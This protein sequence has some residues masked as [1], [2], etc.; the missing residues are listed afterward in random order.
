MLFNSYLYLILFLP[1]TYAVYF[2]LNAK[3]WHRLALG[4]LTLAS[5][6]FY[7]FWNINHLPI[8]L[9]SI[10]GN[11]LL[12]SYLAKGTTTPRKRKISLMFGIAANIGLL[13]YFKY[14]DFLI[15][16]LNQFSHTHLETL[17]LALPLAI[18]FFTFLQI[19]YLVDVYKKPG[20]RYSLEAY[21][22]FVTFFPHLIAGPIVHHKDLIPQFSD[23]E[24]RQVAYQNIALG[25]FLIG[26]GL[27]KKVIIA[28]TFAITADSGFGTR[29]PLLLLEAWVTSLSYTFE[30]Y[31]DFSGYSDIAI[32]S[33]LL[34][35]IT[36]PNNFDS[37]YK[38]KNIQDFWRRWHI[39]LSNFLRDYLYIPLGGNRVGPVREIANVI[40]VFLLGGLW[41]GAGWTFI[42]WG[43]LHGSAMAL[44][45]LWQKANISMPTML[46][47]FITFQFVNIAWI[48]FRARDMERAIRM[49]KG[50]GGM[51]G[52]ALP[53]FLEPY[54]LFFEPQITFGNVF[55]HIKLH[56]ILVPLLWL[57]IALAV[58]LYMKNSNELA[59]KF[60]PNTASLAATI[61]LFVVSLYS[62]NTVSEF[63]YFNF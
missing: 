38:A 23:L 40:L 9:G 30:L 55:A 61:I 42:I 16:N 39:T 29:T 17:N 2:Y 59:S 45:R 14:A 31:F 47:W 53:R 36:L 11:Y 3:A 37:P 7:A 15:E 51:N 25:L 60:K 63:I 34:F 50:M 48:F 27:F 44:Y 20:E 41:H 8:L 22:L 56:D 35:N 54:V 33:A 26:I 49:L 4:T 52:I 5:L 24:K 6:G 21:A 1:L 13:A 10:V 43:I 58:V 57:P 46:A 19:A 18:S 32:G 12:G 28:D 62:M